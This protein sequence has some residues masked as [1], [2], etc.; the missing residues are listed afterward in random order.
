[1]TDLKTEQLP[2]V[3]PIS[4]GAITEIGTREQNQ[5]CMTGFSSPFGAVYLVADGMGGHQGGA[6]AS[7]LVAEAF[8]RHLLAAPP[9]SPLRDAVTLAVRLANLEV[10]EKGRSGNPEYDGMGST[11]VIAIV[12]QGMHGLE[13]TTAHV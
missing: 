13:L 7:R 8:T 2:N 12:R 1:M 3:L 5:D 4:V 9:S 6:E 11:V 10:L